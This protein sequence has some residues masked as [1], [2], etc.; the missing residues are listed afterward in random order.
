MR[1]ARIPGSLLL[2]LGLGLSAACSE[3]E[4]G[5]QITS[6]EPSVVPFGPADAGITLRGYF[7]PRLEVDLSS[8]RREPQLFDQFQVFI[9]SVQAPAVEF[10]SDAEL[11]VRLP[12]LAARRHDVTVISPAGG[13]ASVAQGLQVTAGAP[14]AVAFV[15]EPRSASTGAVTGPI[16]VEL[17]DERG[18][19]APG[20]EGV[21]LSLRSTAQSGGI[22]ETQ[23]GPF[24]RELD[25]QLQG[26]V[27]SMTIYFQSGVPGVYEV[28]ASIA[29]G[30]PVAQN[31]SIGNF[32]APSQLVWLDQPL[33]VTAGQPVQLRLEI[34]DSSGGPPSLPPAGFEVTFLTFDGGSLAVLPSG[35]FT[36]SVQVTA[37]SSRAFVYFRET[38]AGTTAVGALSGGT[39]P[40]ARVAIVTRP[41]PL[42]RF[43]ASVPPC[44]VSNTAF[45]LPATA[46]DEFGNVRRDYGRS[47]QLTSSTG[48]VTPTSTDPFDAGASSTSVRYSGTLTTNCGAQIVLSDPDAGVSTSYCTQVSLFCP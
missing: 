22:S 39:V 40:E 42:A 23:G 6:I 10:V 8:R 45:T 7:P 18:N 35:P 32:G 37:T 27:S 26:V 15:N 21:E 31:V 1:C 38:V 29:A 9:G 4:R 33:S 34:Q 44:V 19:A 20:G 48:T 13:Q 5:P 24:V 2:V 28:A 11:F 17:R 25:F 46:V 14:V 3:S 12:F 16:T 41:A 47:A 30:T 43:D 36:Q